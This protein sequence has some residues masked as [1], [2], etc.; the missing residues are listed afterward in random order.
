MSPEC[1]LRLDGTY[2]AKLA[3]SGDVFGTG[4]QG[5]LY[6]LGAGFEL[7]LAAE[8]T[9]GIGSYDL[10]DALGGRY[11][12]ARFALA[13][14]FEPAVATLGYCDTGDEAAEL[15]YAA[16]AGDRVYVSLAFAF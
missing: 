16:A 13:R 11:T 12:Y 7:P 14:P 4:G 6:E 9:V 8:L 10:S 1:P 5:L 3:Y 2:V 15:F